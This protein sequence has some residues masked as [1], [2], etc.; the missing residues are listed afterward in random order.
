MFPGVGGVGRV[1][2][3]KNGT[4]HEMRA[5]CLFIVKYTQICD[6]LDTVVLVMFSKA[7]EY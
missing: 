1:I 5:N 7:A 4:A 2:L 6:L 3:R